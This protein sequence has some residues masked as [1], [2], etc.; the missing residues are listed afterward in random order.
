MNQDRTD[1]FEHHHTLT[2]VLRLGVPTIAGQIILVL[3]NLADTFFIGLT[4]SDAKLI[5]V[6]VCLPAFMVLSA[7]ANLFGVGGASAI[8]RALGRQDEARARQSS[9]FAVWGAALVTLLYCLIIW[10]LADPIVDLLGGAHRDVHGGAKTYLLV[11]VALGGFCTVGS[12]LLA[13]LIRS[14]GNAA[15]SGIGIIL[16]GLL[17]IGLDPLFM[18]VLLPPGQEVLGAALATALSNLLSCFYFLLALVWLRRRGSRLRFAADTHLLRNGVPR[19]IL[20]T[21]LSACLMT[22]FENISYAVLDNRMMRAGL[23]CQAGIGVA[24]K[25]NMLSHS[26]TRGMAQGV[27]PFLAYNYAARHYGRLKRA[28]AW[29]AGITVGLSLLNMGI[30]LIWSSPLSALFLNDSGDSLGFGAHFLQILCLGAPFSAFSYIVISFFQAVNRNGQAFSLA[31]L[32]KGA[33]DIPMMLLLGYLFP[34]YG[35]VWATP[36][37]DLICC[38]TAVLLFGVWFRQHRRENRLHQLPPEPKAG[39]AASQ[40]HIHTN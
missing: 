26:V 25:L 5:S 19:E 20:G 32:R 14:E 23:A 8:S 16:G 12:S 1:I 24:K 35:L 38:I 30:C 13:H 36:L 33:V 28:L 29:A 37:A 3:Y 27:L 39:E 18:F 21:G 9:A 40:L 17:N 10:L 2:A 11:T 7:I 34:I 31:A 15:I 4:E 6:T 22:L